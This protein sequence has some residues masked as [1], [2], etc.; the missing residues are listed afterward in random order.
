MIIIVGVILVIIEMLLGAITGF[1]LFVLGI[2]FILSAILGTVTNSFTVTLGSIGVF[3]F[4]Y[5]IVGRNF[6][7]QKIS[8]I[9]HLT[10][11]D[12]LVGEKGIVIKEITPKKSGQVKIKGETWRAESNE[13]IP[14]TKQVV[15]E[16]IS[17]VTVRVKIFNE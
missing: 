11:V 2:I 3:S 9:T 12:A 15:V 7:K 14:E 8:V 6:I 5:L 13:I 16:S 17:G 4:L 1:E 10:N